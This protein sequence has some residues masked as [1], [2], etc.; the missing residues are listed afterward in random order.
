MASFAQSAFLS[1]RPVCSKMLIEQNPIANQRFEIESLVE[2]T[3]ILCFDFY[4][5]FLVVL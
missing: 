1:T 5:V 2:T 4:L 3:V